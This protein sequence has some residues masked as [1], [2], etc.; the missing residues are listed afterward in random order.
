MFG[1]ERVIRIGVEGDGVHTERLT[2]HTN[3][4]SDPAQTD[5]AQRLAAQLGTDEAFPAPFD[6][7]LVGRNDLPG[8]GEH[9][10]Q[11]EI[12][13]G[14]VDGAGSGRDDD[15]QLARGIEVDV[16]HTHPVLGD[17]FQRGNR[18][19]HLSGQLVGSADDGVYL[20]QRF[21]EFPRLISA[22]H[23]VRDHFT[24]SSFQLDKMIRRCFAKG[25]GT[26]QDLPDSHRHSPLARSCM[27]ATSAA[28]SG[29]R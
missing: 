6:H 10:S 2:A 8:Q 7:T 23:S 21:S 3:L 28:I 29:T 12:S 16:V 1:G 25:P 11:G 26:D 4:F 9:Q 24:P 13:H 15:S 22:P 17:R 20:G 27:A 19:E 14:I 5:D 18:S